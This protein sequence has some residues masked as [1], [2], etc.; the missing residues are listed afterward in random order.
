MPRAIAF[1]QPGSYSVL[2]LIDVQVPKPGPKEAKIKQK[3]IEVN[4]LDIYHRSGLYELPDNVKIPGISAVGVIEEIGSEVEGF[5]VGDRVGYATAPSGAYCDSRCISAEL[6]FHIPK[7]IPDVVAAAC[8]VKGM[9]AH[10]LATRVFIARP[11]VAVLVHA[12][13]GGVGQMLSKWCNNAGAFVI[14]TVGSDIK[15]QTAYDSGCHEVINYSSQDWPAKV[16]EATK[17]YGVNAVYDSVG[18][19][20]FDGSLECLM[21]FGILVLYG[22][23]SG[24]VDQLEI[25]KLAGK[26]L[27][28]TRPSLFHYKKN[29]MELILSASE[30]FQNLISGSI[31][32][33]VQ[34]ELPLESAAEAHKMLESRNTAGSIVLVP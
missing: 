2:K 26:S 34:A 20:T 10:Y 1:E 23:S 7:E 30:L 18:K 13:A 22:N 11:G 14:G 33:R 3:A 25:K 31:T 8:L 29:R 5:K 27:F 16:R 24:M 15:K 6:L 21:N 12:A 19:V 32:A 28:F 17:G 4:F 9:T